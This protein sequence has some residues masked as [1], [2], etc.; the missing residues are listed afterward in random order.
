MEP[1]EEKP[2]KDGTVTADQPNA[3]TSNETPVT[4][5]G[6]SAPVVTPVTTAQVAP[7]KGKKRKISLLTGLIALAIL[8]AGSAA[9]YFGVVLPN[10]PQKITE[11]AIANTLNSEKIS[12]SG[13]EGEMTFTGGEISKSISSVTFEGAADDNKALDIKVTA[14][15]NVTKVNIDL[16]STDGKS[17]YV[18]LSGLTGLDKLIGSIAERDDATTALTDTLA[19]FISKLNNQWYTIDQSL[20]NQFTGG[21]DLA[22]QQRFNEEDAKKIGEIYKKN[23]FIKVDKKLDDQDIH[24]VPSYHIQASIDNEKLQAFLNDLRNSKIKDFE[25]ISQDDIDSFN[26]I[27]FSKSPIELWV[28]KKDRIFTQV[29]TTFESEGTEIKVRVA[30]KDVNKPVNVEQ[31]SDAKSVLELMSEFA[32]LLLQSTNQLTPSQ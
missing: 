6:A 22:E 12:S 29:A 1:N 4:P 10:Q 19:P 26:K 7:A 5:T 28:S 2:S 31:P 15:T 32:P 8:L 21:A 30:L 14:N 11:D 17:Y 25:E 20:I 23:Q 3:S 24:G 18:R 13:F 9:A 16:R 27:D